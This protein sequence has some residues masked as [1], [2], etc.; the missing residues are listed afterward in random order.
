V[1][2]NAGSVA[3]QITRSGAS[4][5][6]VKVSYSTFNRTATT[7][8]FVPASGV[9]AFAAG[10]TNKNVVVGILND[11]RIDPTLQFSLEL[12]SASGGAWL[13]DRVTTMVNIVDNSTPPKFVLPAF[14][15]GVF[16]AQIAGATG[17]VVRVERTTN[18]LDWVPFQTLTNT[19]G[20]T[21]LTDSN[22][23]NGARTFYR[24]VVNKN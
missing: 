2:K 10:E 17:L 14:A 4:N 21:P 20:M 7:N 11:G 5:L 6:P 9:L 24:A 12:I 23:L 1:D 3:V 8:N 15:N 13:G 19:S 16:H 18:F 22:L